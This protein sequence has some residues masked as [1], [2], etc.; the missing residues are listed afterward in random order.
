MTKYILT[1]SLQ[2][3]CIFT[4]MT[5]LVGGV[6]RR[7]YQVTIKNFIEG[8]KRPRTFT[9]RNGYGLDLY[10]SYHILINN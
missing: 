4:F 10:K 1:L 8:I 9:V 3:F 2:G 6:K 5:K 7:D